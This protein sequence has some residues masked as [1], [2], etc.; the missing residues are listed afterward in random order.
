MLNLFRQNTLFAGI[1][2]VLLA[3]ALRIPEILSP[4]NYS[5]IK[6]A[7]FSAWVFNFIENLGNP[8]F[9]AITGNIFL[10]STQAILINYISS[11]HNILYKETYMP[12]L[13]F[14]LLSSIFPEQSELT[15]QLVSNFFIM[16]LLLRLC[17]LYESANPLLLMLD[18]GF[19]L[20]VGLLFNYDLIIFLPFILI[21][22]IIFTSFNLRYLIVSVLGI[23]LPIYLTVGVFYL[24]DHLNELMGYV[25]QSFE[26]DILRAAIKRFDYLVPF[27][28]I[29]PVSVVSGFNLQQNFFRNKVKTRRIIQTL[30]LMLLFGVAGLFVENNN[31]V[32]A[33]YYLNV[34]LAIIFGYFFISDKRFLLKEG[35]FLLLILFVFYFNYL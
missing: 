16:V 11:R 13:M 35:L 29:F 15:P 14:V 31:F 2:T 4:H 22:V 5:F 7:P 19:Y 8:T 3:A 33:L 9:W 17:Y 6:S 1:L 26:K 34:P 10:V 20:G 23:A 30:A 25:K 24:T 32:Y 18:S 27:A 28:I 12:G 21:S